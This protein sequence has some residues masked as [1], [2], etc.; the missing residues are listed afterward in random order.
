MRSQVRQ[1]ARPTTLIESKALSEHLGVEVLIASETFQHTGSFKF[2][3]AYAAALSSPQS[4]LIAASSGNFGQ[5]L[6]Y[7]ARLTG[8]KAVIVMPHDSAFVKI[9]AVKRHGGQVEL[10]DV[11]VKSRKERVDELYQEMK[12]A[13]VLSAYDDASV[14]AGN[15]TLADELVEKAGDFSCVLVP[16]GG[17]GLIS[18][19]IEGLRLNESKASVYGAEPRLANDASLSLARGRIIKNENEPK[20]IADGAR[21]LSLGAENWKVIESGVTAIIEIEEEAIKE[22]VRL[23]FHLANLKVE[24]TGALS[25]AALLTSGATF[26]GRRAV[27]V[28]SGGNVDPSVYASIISG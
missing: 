14:I 13:R 1:V 6:A 9:D 7:A 23:L 12:N 2:R 15:S 8:K 16:V 27:A 26:R 25:V 3:A 17:G 19:I 18:G 10:V 20:T 11:S 5:A 4:N 21:T 24:P 22:A 28:V